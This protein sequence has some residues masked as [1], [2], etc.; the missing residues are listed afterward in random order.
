[1]FGSSGFLDS[2]SVSSSVVDSCEASTNLVKKLKMYKMTLQDA[3]ESE[4]TPRSMGDWH[5]FST[6][7]PRQVTGHASKPERATTGDNVMGLEIDLDGGGAK[8]TSLAKREC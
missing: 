5:R 3:Q 1:M 6:Q 8:S 7:V 4:E 2:E